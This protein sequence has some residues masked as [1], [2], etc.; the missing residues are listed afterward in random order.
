[1]E[2][3]QLSK[4]TK[5]GAQ[6][7]REVT[8]EFNRLGIDSSRLPKIFPDDSG[9]IKLVFVGQYSAG[10]S[11]IIKML[12]GEDVAIGAAITTQDSTPYEWNG[13]EIIDT[14][15][16]ETELRPDHD[17]ITYEQINHAALL[18]F[19]ITNEGFSQRMGD[20]FRTLAIDQKRADNM[21]LVVN[22][23]DRTALGNVPEQQEVIYEDLKKVTTPHDPKELYLSFVDTASYFK[24]L[25]ETDERRK[26]RRMQRSGREI[27]IANLNHFVAEKG[28]LQKINLPLNTI[29]AEIRKASGGM[30][31]DEKAS[32]AAE[33]E[34]ERQR[35][36]I[37]LDGKS[38][39][40]NEVKRIVSKCKI[41]ITSY[42]REVA[43]KV[44]EQKSKEDAEKIINLAQERIKSIAA[45]H[46]TEIDECTQNF[47]AKTELEIKNYES[48]SFFKKVD[49]DLKNRFSEQDSNTFGKGAAVGVG[50]GG[51]A[52][53][54]A[55]AQ[56][57]GQLAQ[58]A[59]PA[60]TPLGQ[61]VGGA[62]NI[63]TRVALDGQLGIFQ[64]FSGIIA[65]QAS[66]FVKALPFFQAELTAG[67]RV[68]AFIA[69]NARALGAGLAVVGAA[70]GMYMT[71]RDGEKAK[72]RD[73]ERL[74]A[75][76]DIRTDF[77][78]AADNI[79]EQMLDSVRKWMDATITPII[80]SFDEKIKSVESQTSAEKVKSEKLSELLTRTENLIGDIQACK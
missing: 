48:G 6:L 74:K 8:E 45:N 57:S 44:L 34:I 50:G 31:D 51:L 67:Q 68:A 40:L 49:A 72:E 33:V 62:V 11:S 47:I 20:H 46:A 9:K 18:I 16:I 4:F 35:K 15:G 36:N 10:K 52:A 29:A 64:G 21:V 53:G 78:K 75:M 43:E 27:F 41:D 28:V 7:L 19:V 24:A 38:D 22:K 70:V 71:Y 59:M 37:F 25:E 80:N 63:G 39:C 60:I 26:N 2:E 12:T 56:Y 30:S 77:N 13:L 65:N 5:E 32:L 42:G 1:M 54:V 17:E 3:F 58:F 66:N 55:I 73:R 79:G 69:G 14:P 23:M 76:E 61:F